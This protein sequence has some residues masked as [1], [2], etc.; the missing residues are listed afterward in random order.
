MESNFKIN[1][2]KFEEIQNLI[3][4]NREN[5]EINNLKNPLNLNKSFL[6]NFSSIL[7]NLNLNE[8]I[9]SQIETNNSN[10]IISGFI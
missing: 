2:V 9:E 3:N 7:P 1:A 6:Q 10:T 5:K 8:K 4:S